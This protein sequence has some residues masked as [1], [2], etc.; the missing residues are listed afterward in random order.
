MWLVVDRA[1]V[2]LYLS[3]GQTTI[4]GNG[5]CPMLNRIPRSLDQSRQSQTLL[6]TPVPNKPRTISLSSPSVS[7]EFLC[8]SRFISRRKKTVCLP[9]EFVLQTAHS[10]FMADDAATLFLAVRVSAQYSNFE[11]RGSRHFDQGS[12]RCVTADQ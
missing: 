10:T 3:R 9:Y 12:S 4:F 2:P 7:F 8:S 11:A 6:P 5:T 1:K